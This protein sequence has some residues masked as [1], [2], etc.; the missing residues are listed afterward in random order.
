LGQPAVLTTFDMTADVAVYLGG[1]AER[2]ISHYNSLDVSIPT[3]APA[4]LGLAEAAQW[5][6]ENGYEGCTIELRPLGKEVDTGLMQTILSE[7]PEHLPHETED[8]MR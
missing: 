8:G 3:D 5:A 2:A 6:F 4:L 7:Q 1:V